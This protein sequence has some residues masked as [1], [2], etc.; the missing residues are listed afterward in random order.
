MA[1]PAC[2]ITRYECKNEEESKKIAELVDVANQ[3]QNEYHGFVDIFPWLGGCDL[4]EIHY[5]AQKAD[6]TV[7]GWMSVK[8]RMWKKR[9]YLY[10][11]EISAIRIQD[12]SYRGVGKRLH[13]QLVQDSKDPSDPEGKRFLYDF[14]YLYPL[15]EKVKATYVGKWGYKELFPGDTNHEHLYLKLG[16]DPTKALKLDIL[17]KDMPRVYTIQA[18]R[19]AAKAPRD[20]DLIRVIAKNRR[21]VLEKDE[22]WQELA[23]VIGTVELYESMEAEGQEVPDLTER[24]EMIAEVFR[25]ATGGGRNKTRR[26]KKRRQTRRKR[27]HRV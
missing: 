7:C 9:K 26:H 11:S 3:Q 24:R 10:L 22:R 17:P 25:R 6:G 21:D 23:D 8:E 4:A 14:I 18:Y 13:D 2:K 20:E 12:E 19:Y 27:I 15:N 1:E 5:V 16:A